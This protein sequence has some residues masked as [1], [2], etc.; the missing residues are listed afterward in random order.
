MSTKA[1]AILTNFFTD[2]S[3]HIVIGQWPN[4][5]L[6]GWMTAKLLSLLADNPALV[7]GFSGLSTALLVTW[8][9]LEITSGVNGFRRLLG[10]VVFTAT[11]IGLFM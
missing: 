10:A 5:P 4:I 1:Y 8:A 7:S 3:G 2:K 9:Y 6:W 11:T